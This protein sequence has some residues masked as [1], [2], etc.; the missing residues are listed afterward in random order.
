VIIADL[1]PWF[2]Q[3]LAGLESKLRRSSIV[4]LWL[5]SVPLI[6]RHNGF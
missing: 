6:V 3:G 5:T 4:L 1:I 2:W